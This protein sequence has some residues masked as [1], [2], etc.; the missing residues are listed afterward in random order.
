M[1]LESTRAELLRIISRIPAP[2]Q[3]SR[4]HLDTAVSWIRSG[5]PLWRTEASAT[6]PVHLVS[7]FLP[8][9]PHIGRFLLV[10]HRKAGLLLPAGGH[11]EP[12]EDPWQ[13]VDREAGEELRLT[14]C[15]GPQEPV[16]LTVTQTH[17]PGVHTDV[18]L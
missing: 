2:D 18:S 9:D 1:T 3:T 8:R 15:S 13:T 10:H 11:V 17:G 7:Y 16:F 5:A 12:F 14:P 6:P 4:D